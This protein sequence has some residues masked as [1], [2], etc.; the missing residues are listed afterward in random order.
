[1]NGLTRAFETTDLFITE[2]QSE[3]IVLCCGFWFGRCSLLSRLLL[4]FQHLGLDLWKEQTRFQ[5][6]NQ[7]LKF[8]IL[9]YSLSCSG[10]YRRVMLKDG[11]T[12]CCLGVGVQFQHNP[13]VLQRILLQ[14]SAVDLLAVMTI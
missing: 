13:Q 5:S 9:V 8:T 6:H 3:S 7:Q 14:Y 11:M 4:G 2:P 1:M 10:S 12:S